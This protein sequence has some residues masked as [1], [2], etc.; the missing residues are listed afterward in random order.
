LAVPFTHT[1][2]L[3][4]TS[5]SESPLNISPSPIKNVTN[6][7]VPSNHQINIDEYNVSHTAANYDSHSPHTTKIDLGSVTIENSPLMLNDPQPI[8]DSSTKLP[9]PN[10]SKARINLSNDS[11]HLF[12]LPSMNNYGA[13]SSDTTVNILPESSVSSTNNISSSGATCVTNSKTSSNE[14]PSFVPSEE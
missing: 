9:S 13:H 7:N 6:H 11:H 10:L 2:S 5:L 4:T 12:G 8:C 3:S 1:T 14:L